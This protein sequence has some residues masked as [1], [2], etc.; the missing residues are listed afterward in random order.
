V[1]RLS[2]FRSGIGQTSRFDGNVYGFLG[3]VEETQLPPLVKLPDNMSLRQVLAVRELT[4]PSDGEFDAWYGDGPTD[5]R[6]PVQGDELIVEEGGV[7]GEQRRVKVP[8]LQ[9]LPTAW[10]PYFMAPQ[11][12]EQAMRTWRALELANVTERHTTIT[13]QVTK[14]LAA[15][16]VRVGPVGANRSKS[17]LHL[18]WAPSPGLF[19]RE[20]TRW[21]VR[22]L[23]PFLTVAPPVVPPTLV[24]APHPGGRRW[25]SS[26]RN[27]T[28]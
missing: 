18:T 26:G 13:R 19:D 6:V 28:S 5:P 24:G 9:Y 21:A 22:R 20:L 23:S 2:R 7:L 3:E 25:G 16:C 14:W 1:S 17:K 10:A 8:Y 27:D 4:A 15:A 12:P 11:T